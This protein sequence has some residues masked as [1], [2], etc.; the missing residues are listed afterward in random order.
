MRKRE[1]EDRM[2]DRGGEKKSKKKEGE[3][4]RE[5]KEERIKRKKKNQPQFVSGT[6]PYCVHYKPVITQPHK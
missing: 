2:G 6:H 1:P 3:T 5:R 4:E